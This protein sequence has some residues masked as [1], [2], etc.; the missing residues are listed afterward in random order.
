MTNLTEGNVKSKLVRFMLP[1][2]IGNVLQQCY[3]LADAVIVG[4]VIGDEGLAAI[5]ASQSIQFFLIALLMGLGAG[6]EILVSR[7]IG[8]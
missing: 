2:L 5:G 4:Q 8:K 6:S 7:Y 1:I 3:S